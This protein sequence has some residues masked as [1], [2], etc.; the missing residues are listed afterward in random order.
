MLARLLLTLLLLCAGAAS[1]A[2]PLR[3]AVT[4][5]PWADLLR[6]L[7][8]NALEVTQLLPPGVSPHDFDPRARDV[9]RIAQAD[10]LVYNGGPGLDEWVLPLLSAAGGSAET[11]AVLDLVDFE[12]AASHGHDHGHQPG[13]HHNHDE[14][15]P[16]G[17]WINPHIWLD[18]LIAAD[19]LNEL[20]LVLA[21][22]AP[23]HG[24][25]FGREAVRL[26]AELRQLDA[27]LA[28]ILRPLEGA[29]FVPFHDAWPYFA[30]RY[31]LD[32]KLE[33]E[34]VPGR[35]PGPAWLLEA[36]LLIR[37]SG[38]RAI[39]GE[40]QLPLRPAQVLAEEAGLP[41][42]VLDPEGGGRGGEETYQ[43][44]LRHNARVLLEAL[45][46]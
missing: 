32:L 34:P 31:G 15:G 9:L 46:D 2:T 25:L 28:E 43:E 1:A 40:R 10:L 26:E 30:R 6:Q 21:R 8:G 45:G 19:A 4:I 12:P 24:E 42:F 37:E 20:A 13:P 38:A 11:V 33:I 7:G 39:F 17:G 29:V 41:L 18:P 36:L 22:L 14:H 27:E 5:H 23:E 44:L 3:V 16:E 35:E